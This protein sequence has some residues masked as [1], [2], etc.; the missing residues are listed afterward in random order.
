MG[1][2]K[3][4]LKEGEIL[5]KEGSYSDCAYI[6][7]SGALEVSKKNKKGG[8]TFVAVLKKNDIVGELGLIDGQPRSASVT[9]VKDTLITIIT[10][11]HFEALAKEN[12]N[13]LMPIMKVLARRL[14]DSLSKMVRSPESEYIEKPTG[15]SSLAI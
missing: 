15:K 1:P 6:I 3:R 14:R 5:F 8:E 13:A 11:E 4:T 12:P 2:Y 9:A 7:E 10:R